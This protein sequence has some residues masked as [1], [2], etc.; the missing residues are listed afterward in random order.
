MKRK[1]KEEIRLKGEE[2]LRLEI[3]KLE[4]EI[5]QL[6]VE[7]VTAKEKNTSLLRRKAD[8]L[9]VLKT[10][11]RERKLSESFSSQK[12]VGERRDRHED[13]SR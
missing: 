13:I 10:I 6:A 5:S 9:A 7:V 3:K 8:D 4:E 12:T 2:E 11:L 1:Q